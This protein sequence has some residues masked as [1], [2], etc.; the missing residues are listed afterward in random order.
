MDPIL[1]WNDVAIEVH[2]RDFAFNKDPV[3]GD[4]I[5]P[6]QGGPTRTSRALAIVHIAMYDAWNGAKATGNKGLS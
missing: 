1:F 5:K 6:Q 2:R 4:V 3:S